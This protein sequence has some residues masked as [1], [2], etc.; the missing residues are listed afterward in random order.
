MFNLVP[1]LNKRIFPK[2]HTD[3][4]ERQSEKTGD[5]LWKI[6]EEAARIKAVSEIPVLWGNKK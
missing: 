1:P 5:K 2:I 3:K 4:E 6:F